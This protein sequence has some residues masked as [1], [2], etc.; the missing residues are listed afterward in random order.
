M[1]VKVVTDSICDLPPNLAQELGITV[2]PVYVIFGQKAYRDRV[3]ISENEFYHKLVYES[4]YPTT[5]VPSPQDFADAYNK[6]A[7]DTDEIISIHASSKLSG[8]LNSALSGTQLVDRKCRIEIVDSRSISIGLGLAVLAAAREGR[9]GKNLEQVTQFARQAILK[10]H[11]R[12]MADTLK[13]AVRSGRLNKAYGLIGTVLGVRPILGLRDGEAFLAG[14]VRTRA[15]ALQRMYEFAASFPRVQEI[16]LG[17][18]TDYDDARNLA[19]RLKATFPETP[20]YI[21]RVCPAVAIYG[22]PGSMGMAV[23]EW[24]TADNP[25]PR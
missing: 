12:S 16:A 19:Q 10:I 6:L 13:Y 5:S 21:A 25:A 20:V 1:T 15:K 14:V 8:I 11:N 9:A 4:V 17:Y 2:V 24:G 22:G 3:D 7:Q 23:R 18:T